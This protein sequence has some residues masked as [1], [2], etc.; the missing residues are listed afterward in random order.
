MAI[1][2]EIK[3]GTAVVRNDD[4]C[5]RGLSR[6]ELAARWKTVE[7]A[8]LQIDRAASEQKKVDCHG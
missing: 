7:R 8:I 1:V 3:T 4:S 2:K 5:F 6:D